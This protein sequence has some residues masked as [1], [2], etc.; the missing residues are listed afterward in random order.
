MLERYSL[1]AEHS[2][3]LQHVFD[4]AAGTSRPDA[5]TKTFTLRANTRI[6]QRLPGTR[7]QWPTPKTKS[8]ALGAFPLFQAGR[9]FDF[10]PHGATPE[11]Q[12]GSSPALLNHPHHHAAGQQH[13]Y[14]RDS[15]ACVPD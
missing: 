5:K 9:L 6:P 1:H 13:R 12:L 15:S 3:T 14:D 11:F 7:S 10:G 4:L 8:P 2:A